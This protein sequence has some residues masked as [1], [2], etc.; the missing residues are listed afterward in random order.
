MRF[1]YSSG[2]FQLDGQGSN[3]DPSKFDPSKAPLLYIGY[4]KGSPQGIPAFG[5]ACANANQ[6]AIDP[7]QI[8]NP[9]PV[10]LNKNL[11][12]AIIPNTGDPLN[13]LALPT[14]PNTPK[15]YRETD[16][17]YF[18]PRLGFAWD[19]SGNGNT[20]PA[21]KVM[22]CQPACSGGR[23]LTSHS[24]SSDRNARPSYNVVA[25]SRDIRLSVG[26]CSR[27]RFPARSKKC[28]DVGYICSTAM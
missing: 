2:Q 23:S 9:N 25:I 20:A 18:E 28:I 4:C 26:M 12:R 17:I 5:T 15:A 1:G 22:S 27:S 14:D 7:R 13:G 8:N 21:G 10:L 24:Q 19:V 11:V 3:F 6:F 16:P